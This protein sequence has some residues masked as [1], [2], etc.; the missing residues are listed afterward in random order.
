MSSAKDTRG[1]ETS[2]AVESRNKPAGKTGDTS[3]DKVERV[4]EKPHGDEAHDKVI[5]EVSEEIE[6]PQK[7]SA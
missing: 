6:L 2:S 7:G 1:P 4:L 5:K 3:G